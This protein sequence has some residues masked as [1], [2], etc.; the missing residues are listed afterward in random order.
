MDGNDTKQYN[1]ISYMMHWVTVMTT[2][3]EYRVQCS[4]VNSSYVLS[5]RYSIINQS[6]S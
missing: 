4:L 1:V 2:K 6:F 3:H 5:M